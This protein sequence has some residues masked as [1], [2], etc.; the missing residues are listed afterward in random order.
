MGRVDD[1]WGMGGMGAT[2]LRNR[3]GAT[4]RCFV[5]SDAKVREGL[6]AK[7]REGLDA[8]VR[9]GLDPRQAAPCD[10]LLVVN[11]TSRTKTGLFFV[12]GFCSPEMSAQV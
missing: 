3:D 11:L 9:E 7:V 5:A 8:M 6:D 1:G 2:S 12:V 4:S 10:A